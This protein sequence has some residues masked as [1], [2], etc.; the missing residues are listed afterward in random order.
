MQKARIR[1]PLAALDERSM[2]WENKWSN[3]LLEPYREEY[4][5]ILG[6]HLAKNTLFEH[7]YYGES[8]R[9]RVEN[10]QNYFG[11]IPE[12]VQKAFIEDSKRDLVLENL[13]S[14]DWKLLFK[15]LQDLYGKD[16]VIKAEP[17]D[18]KDKE[19]SLQMIRVTVRGT[20]KRTLQDIEIDL[21]SGEGKH[22]LDF[23]NYSVSGYRGC[24]I[25]LE[26]K[27]S[28]SGSDYIYDTCMGVVWH[29]SPKEATES[30]LRV[31]L[32]CRNRDRTSTG[33]RNYPSRIY[34]YATEPKPK[35][36]MKK[37]LQKVA[38][39]L[40]GWDSDADDYEDQLANM[41][42]F[43]IQLPRGFGKIPF[44]RDTAMSDNHS[45]FTYTNIPA[46]CIKPVSF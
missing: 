36:Q 17:V 9:V 26:P 16:Q 11:V 8:L 37:E 4:G 27:F 15:K 35:A 44:Y 33:D 34:V 2:S 40:T 7:P 29:L 43:R 20:P 38:D 41:Q 14:H 21:K 46:A 42:V 10:L 12:N 13:Q 5:N 22:L 30:I 32:R 25:E 28:E 19:R 1:I 3:F 39:K 18:R 6:E 45:F 23:F 31:G 24:W